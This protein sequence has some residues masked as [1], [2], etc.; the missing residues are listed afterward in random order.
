MRKVYRE[1][2]RGVSLLFSM[3][4]LL[5]LTA[6]AAGMMFMSSTETSI[7]SNFKAE[8]T[9]YY[10]A[11]AGVEEVR[12]RMLKTSPTTI[13]C[14]TSVLDCGLLPTATPNPAGGVLYILQNGV[15]AADITNIVPTN[16]LADDELC[17]D[18][19]NPSYGGMTWQPANVRCTDLPTGGAGWFQ[20]TP[21][22]APF[23]GSTNPMEYKW[24]R[25]TLKANNSTFPRLVDASPGAPANNQVCWDGTSELVL[26]T[27]TANCNAMIPERYPVYMITA[28]AV[29]PGGGRR[30]VQQ[31]IAQNPPPIPPGGLFAT[32]TGCGALNIAGNAQTGSFNSS[33]MTP[34][35]NPPS[36]LVTNN[37]NIGANGNLDVGGSSTNVNGSLSTNMSATVGSCPANGITQT[38]NPGMG[39]LVHLANPYTPQVPPLPNP[40]PPQTNVTYNGV[41]LAPGAFGNVTIQGNV[42]LQGGTTAHP[43]VYTMNS[44]NF[45]GQATLTINGPVVLNLAGVGQNTVLDMTG[46]T[47]ANTTLVPSNFVI[48][49]GGTDNIIVTGGTAA[50]AVIDAPKAPISFHGGSNFYGQ[51]IGNTIDDQGGTNFYWDQAV[52][53]PVPNTSSFFEISMRE[54][55]Y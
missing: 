1:S 51:A 42:T 15:S 19:G 55:T 39:S 17:H 41:T 40:L 12:D 30:L 38:G 24:V 29:T 43:A 25:V 7:S 20:T 14:N 18:G 36:N 10:A 21:S 4:A 9:A 52:L 16:P 37:G 47:F 32:G 50:Y 48:N 33:T 6:I 8:Q 11:R 35:V 5:L 26:P 46:G 28:L 22:A 34:G 44:L 53:S 45:N 13:N 3:L 54:L 31:E 27:G 2:E 23:A 49:Y